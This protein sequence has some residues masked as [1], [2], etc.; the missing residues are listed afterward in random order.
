M[1]CRKR[2]WSNN[3]LGASIANQLVCVGGATLSFDEQPEYV[4]GRLVLQRPLVCRANRLKYLIRRLE[5][6]WPL[7]CRVNNLELEAAIFC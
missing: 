6:R 5:L 7:I 1:L 3:R 4:G 2:Y